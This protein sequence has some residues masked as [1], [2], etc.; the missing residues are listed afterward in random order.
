MLISAIL[1]LICAR[2]GAAEVGKGLNRLESLSVHCDLRLMVLVAYGWLE[3]HLSLSFTADGEAE[4]VAGC[5]KN[6]PS[7]LAFP[8]RH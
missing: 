3:H 4:V 6:C 8:A 5:S 7:R 2:D 1:L